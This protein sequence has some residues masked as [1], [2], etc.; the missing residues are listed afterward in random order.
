MGKSGLLFYPLMS[1]GKR[2]RPNGLIY[3]HLHEL[4]LDRLRVLGYPA[5]QL[6]IHSLRVG[7]A[8]ATAGSGVPNRLLKRH[9]R[10]RSETAKDGYVKD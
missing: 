8:T 10:W 2:L 7:G 1:K 5:E 3:S 4:L 6:G 9:G